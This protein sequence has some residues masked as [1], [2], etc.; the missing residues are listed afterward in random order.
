MEQI[1]GYVGHI[2]YRNADNGYTVL[3]LVGNGEETVSVGSFRTLDEGET[4]EVRG[5]Y[6]EHPVY[7]TQLKVEGLSDCGTG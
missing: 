7:G 2:I 3:E 6:V 5:N 1:K 4:L